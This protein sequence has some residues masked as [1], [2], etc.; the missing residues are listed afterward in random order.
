MSTD[1]VIDIPLDELT[2]SPAR[3]RGPVGEA[4]KDSIEKYGILTHIVCVRRKNKNFI[5]DGVQ[6]YKIAKRLGYTTLP[7]RIMEDSK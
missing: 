3:L 4:L 2:V 7:C 1:T 6:R 5:I